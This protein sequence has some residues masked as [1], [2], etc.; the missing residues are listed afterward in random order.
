MERKLWL[1]CCDIIEHA[2]KDKDED[3]IKK[4]KQVFFEVS[5]KELASKH[6][7]YNPR[8]RKIR[9]FNLSRDDKSSLCTSLHELAH[10]I[11]HMNR[12][13]SDHSKEFYV[14]FKELIKAALE[15]KL[16]TEEQILSLET[17]ASDSNKVKKI[18]EELNIDD[19]EDYKADKKLIQVKNCF[20]IKDELKQRQYS[21]NGTAKVWE[22]EVDKDNL[23]GELEQIY[24]LIDKINVNVI[25]ANV[26]N[27]DCFSYV[28]VKDSYEFKD[29]LKA[30]GYYYDGKK[31]GWKK[32]FNNKEIQDEAEYI[33]QLGLTNIKIVS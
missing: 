28:L 14:V 23:N 19:Y 3:T 4:Y 7:D 30:R 2:F 9:I 24:A 25:D 29:Q 33:R 12:D 1:L 26:I 10:H 5:S 8:E 31:K 16:V 6:G 11:D 20:S 13:K 15:M 17:D 22:K 18:V 32:K 27:F 21:W